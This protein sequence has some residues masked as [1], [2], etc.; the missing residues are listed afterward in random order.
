MQ[1][2]KYCKQEIDCFADMRRDFDPRVV[3]AEAPIA[4][5]SP[6]DP[7]WAQEEEEA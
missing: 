6:G 1:K 4:Q 7:C 5:D 3:L 2:P